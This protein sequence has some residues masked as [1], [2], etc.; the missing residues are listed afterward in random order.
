MRQSS[1]Q[2]CPVPTEQQPLNEYEELKDSW[3]FR[4][5]TLDIV[6]Y[7][8]KLGWVWLWGWIIASPIAAASFAPQKYPILF[9]I[10][11]ALGAAGLVV[12]ALARL[13]LGWSYVG[14]RLRKEK[15]F[16]EES[17]WY[18]GQIWEKPTEVLTRDRLVVSYQIEPILQRLRR[19]ALLLL[20]LIGSGCLS[21]LLVLKLG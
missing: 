1:V 9:A 7:S 20:V 17:G 2:F 18:D 15:V 11:S 14:D 10:S 21:W 16:Y 12:L 3:P 19:T 5:A 8:R 13:Y 6:S 4:W